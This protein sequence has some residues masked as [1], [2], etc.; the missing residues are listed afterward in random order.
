MGDIMSLNSEII[1]SILLDVYHSGYF[2]D[3]D[4]YVSAMY[5]AESREFIEN[6]LGPDELNYQVFITGSDVSIGESI[7]FE[8]FSRINSEY[9]YSY[10]EYIDDDTASGDAVVYTTV[11]CSQSQSDFTQ[12]LKSLISGVDG[13][14]TFI[15]FFNLDKASNDTLMWIS[16]W[17][18]NGPDSNLIIIFEAKNSGSHSVIIGLDEV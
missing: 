4:S 1:K 3:F 13:A 12:D 9:L 10:D 15:S 17:L 5:Y 7:F 16:K 6:A 14:R 8:L 11:D 18:E 2:N